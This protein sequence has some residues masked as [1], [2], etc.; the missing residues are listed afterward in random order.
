MP[1]VNAVHLTV[2]KAIVTEGFHNK[3]EEISRMA[4]GFRNF[5]NDRLRVSVMCA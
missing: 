3:M 4:Y 2:R 5:K 1:I